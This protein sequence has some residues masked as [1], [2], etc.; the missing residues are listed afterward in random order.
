MLKLSGAGG[1]HIASTRFACG[2]IVEVYPLIDFGHYPIRFLTHD[3][4]PSL[5]SST[6]QAASVFHVHSAKITHNI[7]ESQKGVNEP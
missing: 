5:L 7:S 4:P 1:I 3:F 6:L 2:V